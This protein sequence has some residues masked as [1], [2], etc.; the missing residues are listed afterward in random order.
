MA[1]EKSSAGQPTLYNK[2]L[3]PKLVHALASRGLND[4]GIYE[5]LEISERTF[6]NWMKIHPEFLQSI[7]HAR[8]DQIS[9]V[10]NSLFERA[11]GFEYTAEKPMVVSNGNGMGS[12]IEIATYTERVLPDVAAIKM[13]LYNRDPENWKDRQNIEHSG[14]IDTQPMSREERA[15]RKKELEDQ[16]A[17]DKQIND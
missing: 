16:I 1:K 8:D 4:K 9:I 2:K 12:E 15:K 10:K 6:Y 11:K 3:H 7:K 17:R 14:A 5:S 13:F